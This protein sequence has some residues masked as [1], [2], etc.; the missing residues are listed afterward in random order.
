MM[1][2]TSTEHPEAYSGIDLHKR[3]L[4]I[5]TLDADGPT[6]REA[7]LKSERGAVLAY[8]GTFAGPHRAVV[9][10]VQSW[11]WLRDPAGVD[12]G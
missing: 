12:W 11:Y 6:T 2:T 1:A 10:C 9:E 5:H 8:F 3:T 4:V 7:A